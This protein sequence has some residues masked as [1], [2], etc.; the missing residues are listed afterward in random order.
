MTEKVKFVGTAWSTNIETHTKVGM[1]IIT[2]TK[3]DGEVG[4]TDVKES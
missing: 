3:D 4:D 1:A 2:T